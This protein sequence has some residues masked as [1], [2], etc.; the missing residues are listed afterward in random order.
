MT[1][2]SNGTGYPETKTLQKH[3]IFNLIYPS[4]IYTITHKTGEETNNDGSS[5]PGDY[6]FTLIGTEGETGEH[7]CVANRGLG[8]TDSCTIEDAANIGQLTS[9][10]VENLSDDSWVIKDVSVKVN[11]VLQ[12]TWSG[13]M[14]F[15][16]YATKTVNFIN[17]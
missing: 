11:G 3:T 6:L 13:F 5:D 16:D 2:V 17:G 4:V 12:G 1:S 9:M 10:K 8:V 7:A 15:G 14:K